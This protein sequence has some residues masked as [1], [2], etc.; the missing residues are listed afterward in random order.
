MYKKDNLYNVCACAHKK[1]ASNA[2]FNRNINKIVLFPSK[3]I[4]INW[5]QVRSAFL[6]LKEIILIP[7]S[8]Y[9]H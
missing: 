8:T 5:K 7:K 9:S 1:S 2:I 6:T 3:T 4:K